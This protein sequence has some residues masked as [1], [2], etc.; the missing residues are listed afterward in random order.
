MRIPT[1]QGRVA[2]QAQMQTFTPNTGLSDIGQAIGGALQAKQA[3]ADKEIDLANKIEL[4]NNDVSRREG[5]LKVDDFLSSTFAEKTTILRNDVAK[6]VMTNQQANEQLKSW[7]EDQYKQLT[8]DLP[9]HAWH[10]YKAQVDNAVGRQSAGF[11]PLQLKANEEKSIGI[12]DRAFNIGTRLPKEQRGP[13]F[14]KYLA[15]APISEADKDIYR[16]K[17]NIEG[18][19]IDVDGRIISAINSNN[20][21][22]LT[23]L[24]TELNDGKYPHLSGGQVQD[25][26]ASISSKIHTLQQRQQVLENKRVSESNKV[27]NEFQQSVLTGRN[28][29]SG[30]IDNVR[31]AVQGTPNQEDFEFYLGQSNNFQKFSKL[32]TDEQLKLLNAQKATMKNASTANA[33]R[34]QKV[35]NVYQSIYNQ[36][37]Q[38]AKDNPNQ[39]LS[40]AGIKIPELNP[41]EMKVNPHGFAKNVIEIGSYQLAMKAKDPNVSIKPISPDVLPQ[42]VESFDKSTVDQKLDLIGNI[43]G[44][45]KGINGGK[46]LWEQTLKQLGGGSL[47]YVAAGTARLNNFHSTEGRDLATSIISGTQLLKNKQFTMPKEADMRASFNSYVGQTVS[48]ETANNAYEVFKAVYADTM[49]TRGMSHAKSDEMPNKDIAKTALGMATGGVYDQSGSFRNYLGAK[50]KDWKVSK[51]YGMTDS[52]FEGRLDKGYSTISAQTGVDVSDL[53]SL[54]LRQAKPSASGELQYD[55]INERGQPLVINNAIWRIKMS[56]VTK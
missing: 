31:T 55:L 37:I 49:V 24:S 45:T 15:T 41:I 19:K 9:M 33:V 25:Y 48:G 34:E 30:Y 56:G 40:E 46:E 11:L 18:D 47:N 8:T 5:Q 3:K 2:P 27:F 52:A 4:Y 36:K 35:M 39:L 20:T 53:Q 32:S 38:S 14:E 44:Q 28:L 42:A 17:Y 13:Y 51:P 26:Q 22:D 16:Q 50:Y 29:E 1:S 7:T 6:G 23:K 43:I 21:E 10:E 12:I 54:R